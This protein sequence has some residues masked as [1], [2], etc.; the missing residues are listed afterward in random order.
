MEERVATMLPSPRRSSG[1]ASRQDRARKD[2]IEGYRELTRD[3]NSQ[4]SSG[5]S[6][7]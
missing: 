5:D 6:I 1:G 4:P 3:D 2:R 7:H